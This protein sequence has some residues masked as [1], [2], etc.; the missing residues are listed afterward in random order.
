MLL[1][2]NIK[3]PKGKIWINDKKRHFREENYKWSLTFEKCSDSLT[4]LI[5]WVK[6][7]NFTKILMTYNVCK[8]VER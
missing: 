3:I 6:L 5:F 2:S 7:T 1:L 8:R 4:K